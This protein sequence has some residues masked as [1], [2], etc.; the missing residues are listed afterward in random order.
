[1]GLCKFLKIKQKALPL[2]HEIK[3]LIKN[4]FSTQILH[5]TRNPTSQNQQKK[6]HTHKMKTHKIF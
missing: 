2:V 6:K 3:F 1:M 4:Y 5:L